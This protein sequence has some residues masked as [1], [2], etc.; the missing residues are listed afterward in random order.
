ML[1]RFIKNIFSCRHKNALKGTNE[2]FCPDCGKYLKKRY[3][4]VRCADCDVK[5]IAKKRFDEITPVDK[6]CTCCGSSDFVI[7]Q[8]ENLNFVDINYAIEVKEV[9]EDNS[10]I[11]ELEIWVDNNKENKPSKKE[12]QNPPLISEMKY[13][14][15]T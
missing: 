10:A 1:K 3:Y 9:I 13:L 12:N 8:Y 6:F 4:V 2:G 5:R 7:E 11:N 14:G 15:T